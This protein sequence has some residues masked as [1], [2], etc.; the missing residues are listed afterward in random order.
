MSNVAYLEDQ[1]RKNALVDE[2]LITAEEGQ[3]IAVMAS[4]DQSLELMS[5][6]MLQLVIIDLSK[7]FERIKVIA[8]EL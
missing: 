2:A 6:Q 7:K 8:N 5:A 3:A 4:L 1:R